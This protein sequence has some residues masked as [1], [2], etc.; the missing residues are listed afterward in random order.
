MSGYGI[1][2]D[3]GVKNLNGFLPL[4]TRKEI[5]QALSLQGLTPQSCVRANLALAR[6]MQT[7]GRVI[8]DRHQFEYPAE[9][10]RAVLDYVNRELEILGIEAT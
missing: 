4:D 5:E 9:L 6:I 2:R 7:H 10:E 1:P 8:A 3:R